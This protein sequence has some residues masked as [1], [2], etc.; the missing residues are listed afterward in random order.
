[1]SS[2]TGVTEIGPW[3]ELKL[4]IIRAYA[5]EYAKILSKQRTKF[6]YVYIDA[7]AGAGEHMS[8]TT[9]ERIAGS[10]Q[11]ALGITPPFHEYYFI[12][13]ED[14][15]I[16]RLLEIAKP[17]PN[18]HVVGGDCNAILLRD[19]FPKMRYEDYVRALCLIDPYGLHLDW[20]VIADA[21]ARNTI[22]IFLNFPLMDITRNVLLTDVAKIKPA[23]AERL[24]RFW[25]DESWRSTVYEPDLFGHP[26]KGR[27]EPLITAFQERLRAVAKF[28]FVPEP[29]PMRNSTNSV[30][31]YLFFASHN[32]TGAKIAGHLFDKYRA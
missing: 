20:K 2:D 9:G 6:R 32:E 17:R 30:V 16:S 27:T 15:K 7:F 3:S 1:M 22:E 24:T 23:Q 14:A 25:G 10:P 13:I 29:L 28:E 26:L 11:V 5:A 19:V 31:Y 18:V 4:E 12:D 8:R 21:S